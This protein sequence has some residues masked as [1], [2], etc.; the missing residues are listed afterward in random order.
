MFF[1]APRAII[2]LILLIF[3]NVEN[4]VVLPK[5]ERDGS[6]KPL[7]YLAGRSILGT[8][9]EITSVSLNSR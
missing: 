9:G 5:D 4:Y 7:H 6:L 8:L 2:P 1:G 3:R